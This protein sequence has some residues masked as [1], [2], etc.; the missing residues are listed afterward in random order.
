MLETVWLK[1]KEFI[2]RA[3]YPVNFKEEPLPL[4]EEAEEALWH[5]RQNFGF[6]LPAHFNASEFVRSERSQG[7]EEWVARHQAQAA[8]AFRD[9]RNDTLDKVC[10]DIATK[11]FTGQY[12]SGA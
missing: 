12:P 2:P 6:Q 11:T 3:G 10:T 4:D 7:N 9:R 5:L 8:A 1:Q